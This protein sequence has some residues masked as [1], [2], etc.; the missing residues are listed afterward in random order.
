[1]LDLLGKTVNCLFCEAFVIFEG[2]PGNDYKEHFLVEHNI[3]NY[4]TNKLVLE[5]LKRDFP[6]DFQ[7]NADTQTD[8]KF[9][10]NY[11]VQTEY[12]EE[13]QDEDSIPDC[14]PSESS[15]V[16]HE[17]LDTQFKFLDDFECVN[18]D[19]NTSNNSEVFHS[20][21]KGR[22]RKKR[23]LV[24]NYSTPPKRKRLYRHTKMAPCIV[25]LERLSKAT[26]RRLTE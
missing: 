2:L 1:M 16:E 14:P 19:D 22:T 4:D 5:T 3:K 9:L 15:S 7:A 8:A 12:Q 21:Y 6:K 10:D 13:S 17:S 26:I 18:D 20:R 25:R 23:I 24:E 11:A